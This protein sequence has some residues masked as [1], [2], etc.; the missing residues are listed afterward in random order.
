MASRWPAVLLLSITLPARAETVLLFTAEGLRPIAHA[1]MATGV[2]TLGDT[3]APLDA[4]RFANPGNPDRA[5]AEAL[6]RLD[7]PEGQRALALLRERANA[8][9]MAR[10]LGIERLPAVLVAP[11][12]AERMPARIEIA[13]QKTG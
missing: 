1:Q 2:F 11:G 9:A 3:R 10:L 7:A 8:A 12:A 5:R 4:L 13:S 6:A